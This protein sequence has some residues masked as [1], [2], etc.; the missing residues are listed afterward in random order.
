[1]TDQEWQAHYEITS[2]KVTPMADALLLHK[3]PYAVVRAAV[4][5]V[6]DDDT[7]M[8][9]R[10]GMIPARVIEDAAF[11]VFFRLSSQE[12]PPLVDQEPGRDATKKRTL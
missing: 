11:K 3:H 1:M 12:V 4:Q 8:L 5:V 10:R 6:L 7:F 9:Q 2:L